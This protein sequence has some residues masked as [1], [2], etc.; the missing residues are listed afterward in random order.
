MQLEG[1]RRVHLAPGQSAEVSFRLGPD[2]LHMLDQAMRWIVEP[3]RFR[4]MVGASSKDIRLR[5]FLTVR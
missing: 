2:E 5:G 4:V 3:G 1:F